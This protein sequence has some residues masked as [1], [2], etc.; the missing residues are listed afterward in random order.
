MHF[1]VR[2]TFVASSDVLWQQKVCGLS[3]DTETK[4]GNLRLV[5]VDRGDG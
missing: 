1:G 2:V 4:N 5:A 3:F